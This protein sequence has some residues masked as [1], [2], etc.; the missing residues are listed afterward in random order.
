MEFVI[1]SDN[2]RDKISFF[3]TVDKK[4]TIIPF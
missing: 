3:L 2:S 4:H 1:M